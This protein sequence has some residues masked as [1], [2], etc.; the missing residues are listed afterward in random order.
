MK[1]ELDKLLNIPPT[2]M[3]HEYETYNPYI[4]FE[5]HKFDDQAWL[6]NVLIMYF[7]PNVNDR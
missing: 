1:L 5:G 2:Q 3:T 7:L 6:I 4:E